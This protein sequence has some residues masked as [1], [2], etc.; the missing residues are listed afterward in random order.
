MRQLRSTVAWC[1]ANRP[2]G[3]IAGVIQY[4][5]AG[6]ADYEGMSIPAALAFAIKSL[7]S[8]LLVRSTIFSLILSATAPARR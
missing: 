6:I 5:H 2:F 7:A 1:I 3:T 8:A 4:K